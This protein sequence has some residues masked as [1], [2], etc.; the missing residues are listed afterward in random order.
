MAKATTKTDKKLADKKVN[1]SASD[2][3]FVSKETAENAVPVETQTEN[4]AAEV[5]S[6]AE[7]QSMAVLAR[8][9]GV[10]QR[11]QIGEIKNDEGVMC[12]VFCVVGQDGAVST[13]Y[14][15]VAK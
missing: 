10:D 2:G 15:P 6:D 4:M 11:R 7:R 12:D 14:E 13:V 8:T 1:K 9:Q 5:V 3:K